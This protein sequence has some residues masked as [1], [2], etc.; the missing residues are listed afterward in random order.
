M[1]ISGNKLREA[2]RRWTVRR[3]TVHELFG[4]SLWFFDSEKEDRENPETLMQKFQQA[5]CAIAQL[6]VAQS[7]YNLK[8]QVDVSPHRDHGKMTLS[9]AIKRVGGVGRAEK[10]W[11]TAASSKSADRGYRDPTVRSK[12][13]EHAKKAVQPSVAA[14]FAAEAARLA[15]QYRA[16]ISSANNVEIDLHVDAKLFE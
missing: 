13:E 9:E 8:N 3:D 10:M 2:I 16:A 11:R 7:D 14:N 6:Q 12:D 15:S 5:D 4:D 1:K